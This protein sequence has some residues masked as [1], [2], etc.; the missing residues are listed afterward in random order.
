MDAPVKLEYRTDIESALLR[1]VFA[2]P[3]GFP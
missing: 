3:A 1:L 2:L